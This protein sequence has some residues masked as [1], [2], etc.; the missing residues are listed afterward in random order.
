MQEHST[1]G[2]FSALADPIQVREHCL[3]LKSASRG[4][5]SRSA[6]M[7]TALRQQEALVIVETE[8]GELPVNKRYL[9]CSNQLKSWTD[10]R[11]SNSVPHSI[12]GAY[13]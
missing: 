7:S 8:S 4:N 10:A 3:C 5:S 12:R 6:S 9:L 2:F 1:V 13:F 11:K